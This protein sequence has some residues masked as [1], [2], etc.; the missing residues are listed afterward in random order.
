MGGL[1]AELLATLAKAKPAHFILAGRN[2]AKILPVIEQIQQINADIK[3][4][5]VALDLLDNASVRKAAAEIDAAADNI[6]V[7]INNAGIAA[8][9]EFFLS[10]DG[11]EGHLAA[12]YLGHFVL[13][14]L[15]AAKIIASKG[16]VL[17]VASMA[18]TLA[19]TSTD[20]PNFNVAS[21]FTTRWILN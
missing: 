6:D 15:L 9:R 5:F 20:D 11:I 13:T 16:V 8:K 19:E 4:T 21:S 1:G 12:N 10:N 7:I 3:T 18:Y 14:N 2:E 17:N